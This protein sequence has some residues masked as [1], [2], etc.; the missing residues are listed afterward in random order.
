MNKA[1]LVKAIAESTG[2]TQR[3]CEAM[4]NAFMDE[5]MKEVGKGGKVSL[6]GFG[7]FTSM[8]RKARPGRNPST[9]AKIKIPARKVPKFSA[10]KEFKNLVSG[11]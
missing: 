1:I 3:A 9:G 11:K 5:V 4:L 10:G 6:V 8:K 7:S 2:N